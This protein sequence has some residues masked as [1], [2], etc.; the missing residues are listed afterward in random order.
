[1]V[2]EIRR[3][4]FAFL[5]SIIAGRSVSPQA[6]A[7][8]TVLGCKDAANAFIALPT[9]NTLAAVAGPDAATCWAVIAS[10][11]ADL[12]HLE[13]WVEQGNR[14]AAQ[15]LAKHLKQ[16]DGG[17]LEDALVALGQFSDHNMERLLFFAKTEV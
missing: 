1:M 17:N 11:N 15:Y 9:K 13:H 12:N 5:L 14:W 7:S 3:L 2:P 8:S 4:G 6:S 10:S 16:L